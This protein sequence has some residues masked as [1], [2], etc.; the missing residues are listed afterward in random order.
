MITMRK[1]TF[2]YRDLDD[3]L[4]SLGFTAHT[5]KGKARVYRHEQTGASVFLP[6]TPFEAEVMW[7]HLVAA[8]HMLDDYNLGELNGVPA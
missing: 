2:T 8:R 5:L 6:D 4:R 1:P 3:R 7:R